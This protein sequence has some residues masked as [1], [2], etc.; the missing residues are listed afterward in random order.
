MVWVNLGKM[1]L[2][3]MVAAGTLVGRNFLAMVGIPLGMTSWARSFMRHLI[4]SRIMS[5][6]MLLVL[7]FFISLLPVVMSMGL[8]KPAAR[9]QALLLRIVLP[10]DV[11]ELGW[12]RH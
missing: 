5:N 4:T 10:A 12:F 1:I 6:V 9:W 7:G 2:M 3:V 11:K 8:M